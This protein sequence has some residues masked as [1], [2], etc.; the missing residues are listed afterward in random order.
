[1]NPGKRNLEI[2]V[3]HLYLNHL[4]SRWRPRLQHPRL[5]VMHRPRLPRR[6]PPTPR[7]QKLLRRQ[8]LV[9]RVLPIV[10]HKISK[11]RERC[12]HLRVARY[13]KDVW[14]VVLLPN[15]R[16]PPNNSRRCPFVAWI[17]SVMHQFPR[18]FISAPSVPNLIFKRRL[19]IST[20]SRDTHSYITRDIRE[21]SFLV[22]SAGKS[23]P[24]LIRW[25]ITWR[26]C[27]IVSC[28]RTASCPLDCFSRLS[29]W[30]EDEASLRRVRRVGPNKF[31]NFAV[32][33][34]DR[35]L[36][37]RIKLELLDSRVER[38]NALRLIHELQNFL[39]RAWCRS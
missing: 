24:D 3:L 10:L 28:P 12:L 9:G 19:K 32:G 18:V 8:A 25:R 2:W 6:I 1:M 33:R 13:P 38:Q 16:I 21:K 11:T 39:A 31:Q 35:E 17:F 15:P 20:A 27:M 30:C 26:Q 29:R 34:L 14:D 5:I 37:D 23:S 22:L 4:L 36:R 7:R